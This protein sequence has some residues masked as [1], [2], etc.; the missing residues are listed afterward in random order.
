MAEAN[1]RIALVFMPFSSWRMPS[2]GISLLKSSVAQRGFACDIHY[3]NLS[4]AEQIGFDAYGRITEWFPNR[5]LI[6]EWLFAPT[7]FGE[8]READLQYV[9][10]VLLGDPIDKITPVEVLL[11]L[12]LRDRIA[13]FVDRCFD[14]VDW[15]QYA[16]VG[17][18][19][20]FHQNCA[21][22]ALARRIKLHYPDIPIVL[23][24]SNCADGMGA[25]LLRLFPFVDFVCPGEGDL[26]FPELVEAVF[27]G[28][29]TPTIPG[30]LSR[31]DAVDAPAS[32]LRPA[33]N[34]DALPCA[35]FTDY[36]AQLKRINPPPDIEVLIPLETAR[37]CWWAQTHQCVFCGLNGAELRFRSKSPQRVLNELIC[38]RENYGDKHRVHITDNILDYRYFRTLLPELAAQPLG[39]SFSLELKANLKREQIALLAKAGITS[40]QPGIES[41]S[42][43]ILKLMRKGTTRLQN[44]QTLKW[45]K[46]Y[47]ISTIWN[48]LYGFPSEDPAEYAAMERL[49]P[50]LLH[51][52]APHRCGHI[53][54]VRFSPYYRDPAANGIT[55]LAPARTYGHIYHPLGEDD[56]RQ[57]ADI[58]EAEYADD[59][60][61]YTQGLRQAVQEW[62]TRGDAVLDVF[63]SPHAIRIVDTRRLGEKKEYQFAGVAADVYLLCDAAR[64]V[65]EL[66]AAPAIRGLA[67]ESEVIAALDR[68]VEDGLMIRQGR[69]YLSL[70]VARD[71]QPATRQ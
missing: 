5:W 31:Q 21:S 10:Q 56:L 26:A 46:Q 9:G 3:F 48:I 29:P 40:M 30:M 59:S 1:K 4:L 23:G 37:G 67:T 20:S 54:F 41:L 6:G 35:D 57:L 36:F 14:A 49:V 15:S 24:G 66:M 43:S 47:G 62:Q 63:P 69:Q 44:I 64:S 61:T 12:D 38:L 42:D 32:P 27:N 33:P 39:L 45:S 65:R 8:N 22:L 17:F 55:S 51:L 60:A 2:L 13:G 16:M 18:S 71:G 58:F 70:A 28:D 34:L 53:R 50:L 19:T 52:D 11:L 25:S 68:F 7:L